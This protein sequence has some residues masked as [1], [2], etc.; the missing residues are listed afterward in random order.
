MYTSWGLAIVLAAAQQAPAQQPPAAQIDR[1]TMSGS[2]SYTYNGIKGFILR[3][4]E[5][6]PVDQFGFQPTPEVR[7]F[8]QILAHIADGNYLLCSPALGEANPSGTV[9][10]AIEKEKLGREALIAKLKDSFTYCDRAYAGLTDAN[11][12]D[13]VP[14]MTS[15][16]PRVALLWFHIS[17]AFEHYGNLVTYMRLKGIVPPS[18]ER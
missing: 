8:G 1:T 9:M 18:S 17:H 7:S 15:K 11:A 2:A 3:S 10:D 14:L 13:T 6:M 12:G 4:A 5:K 16:R